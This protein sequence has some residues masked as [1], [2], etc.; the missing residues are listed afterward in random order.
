MAS[1]LNEI[2]LYVGTG[3]ITAWGI[4]NIELT[5]SVVGIFGAISL[6]THYIIGSKSY[7]NINI[8]GC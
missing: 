1:T 8:Y 6:D 3:V 2:L 4:A 7:A 5:K